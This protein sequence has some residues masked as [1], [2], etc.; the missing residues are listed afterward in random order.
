MDIEAAGRT[1]EQHT[2]GDQREMG[3]STSVAGIRPVR[4]AAANTGGMG[5]PVWQGGSVY[6]AGG[7]VIPNAHLTGPNGPEEAL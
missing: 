1:R 3:S 2:G 4:I 5:R 7:A 6:V